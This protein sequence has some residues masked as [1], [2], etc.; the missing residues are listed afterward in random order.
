MAPLTPGLD[1]D[2]I[3][4]PSAHSEVWPRLRA[5]ADVAV[6]NEDA[7]DLAR[8]A[9]RVVQRGVVVGPQVAPQPDQRTV[10]RLVHARSVPGE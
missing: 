9:Q 5:E 2:P 6:E 8:R 3:D 7:P 1:L 4:L 10:E